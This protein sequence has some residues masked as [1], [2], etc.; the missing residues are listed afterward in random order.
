MSR[1]R[2]RQPALRSPSPQSRGARRQAPTPSTVPH[3]GESRLLIEMREGVTHG[4]AGDLHDPLERT[5]KLHDQEDG[6]R[7]RQRTDEEDPTTVAFRGAKSP[8]LAKMR[9]I[10]KTR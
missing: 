6:G 5:A 2:P 7:N 1:D 8:K 9:L 3:P 10:Q 4:A